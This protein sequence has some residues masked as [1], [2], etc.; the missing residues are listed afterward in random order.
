[1][2]EITAIIR[3]QQINA[4]KV[5]CVAAG[6][7]GFTVRKVLG[8][9]RGEVDFRVLQAASSGHEEAIAQLGQGPRLIPKRMLTFI[10][11]DDHVEKLVQ[12]IIATNKTGNHGDG[13]IFVQDVS[14]SVRIRTGERGA[15][16]LDEK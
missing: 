11:P 8:R 12:T 5:A 16:A 7:S 2:K 1:M 14:D 15:A 4:T 3:M 10:V 9:G 13:K 6:I